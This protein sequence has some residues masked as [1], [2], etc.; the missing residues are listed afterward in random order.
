M[1]LITA[2]P[3]TE[4]FM[5]NFKKW[6]ELR[7]EKVAIESKMHR[8]SKE[9]ELLADDSVRKLNNMHSMSYQKPPRYAELWN[10]LFTEYTSCVVIDGQKG[11][12]PGLT[13]HG[14]VGVSEDT[15]VFKSYDQYNDV[16]NVEIP[17]AFIFYE[18]PNLIKKIEAEVESKLAEEERNAA[19]YAEE[20]ERAEYERLKAKFEDGETWEI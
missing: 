9:F 5:E 2:K 12:I 15:A 7:L 6:E 8:L 3:Y 4:K 1:A 16:I 19:R 11:F 17:I 10:E 13:L 18:V 14:L 20:Q